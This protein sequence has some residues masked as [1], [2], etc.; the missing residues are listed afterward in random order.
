MRV[1]VFEDNLMWS[2]RLARAIRALGHEASVL[3]APPEHETADVAIVN[4]GSAALPGAELGASLA[5]RGVYV[6]GHAGHKETPLLAGGRRAG[7]H[8]VAT[9]RETTE[10][11]G[12]LLDE[13]G[14]WLDERRT[15][16]KAASRS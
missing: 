1:W 11:L 9:N 8:R 16:T 6:I 4:L 7:C 10:R 14:R 12:N 2:V 3:T 15:G 13:A 5:E